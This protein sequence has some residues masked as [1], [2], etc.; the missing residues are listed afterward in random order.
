MWIERKFKKASFR[1]YLLN[2]NHQV[3]LVQGARQVGKTSFILHVFQELCE[4]PQIRLNLYYPT[5]FRLNGVDYYGRDFFGTSPTG[6]VFL[7]NI[8]AELGGFKN[9]KKPALIFID[10]ADQYPIS[11]E[12]I[13]TLAEFSDKLKFVFTGSNLE[14][15]HLENAATGRKKYFDL[16]PITFK[17]FLDAGQQTKLSDYFERVSFEER[18]QSSFYHEKLQEQFRTYLRLG[19]M[20]R[21]VDAYWDPSSTTQPIPEIMK[22]LAVTIEENVKTVLGE[23]AKLYEYEDILRKLAHLS[24]NTLKYT[25]LQVQHAGRREAKK[26]VAKTVGARVAHKIRLYAAEHDLSKYILFDCG[27]VHYLLNGADVLKTTMGERS[28]AIL[29]ETFVGNELIAGM[30]T[31]DDLFYWKSGNRAEVEFFL[32]SPGMIGVE[33]KASR[34][35]NKSLNSLALLEPDVTLLVKIAE[36]CPSF[37]QKY[38][39]ALPNQSGRRVIPMMRIPHYLVARLSSLVSL[40]H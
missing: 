25:H 35:D 10:E 29:C 23:T 16:Y 36:G 8:E 30:T 24:L 5:S 37:T 21:I 28:R 40:I 27:L 11:L 13:Q 2:L 6:E 38:E 1:E 9:L 31:R 3:L 32:K 39:A 7:R 15:I 18:T 4:H 34:G 12:A 22:D 17:E 26:L 33:V 20:P 19:G 14:N